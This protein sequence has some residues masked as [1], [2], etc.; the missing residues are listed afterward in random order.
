MVEQ[1]LGLIYVDGQWWEYFLLVREIDPADERLDHR[2]EDFAKCCG[3]LTGNHGAGVH[4]HDDPFLSFKSADEA[5][6]V[7]LTDNLA[8]VPGGKLHQ[9][10]A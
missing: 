7:G 9:A 3:C 2:Q 10:G 4:D 5:V 1:A 6:S 8:D